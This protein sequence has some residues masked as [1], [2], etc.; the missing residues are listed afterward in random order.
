MTQFSLIYTSS[1]DG[2]N[3]FASVRRDSF[4]LE[5]LLFSVCIS[6]RLQQWVPNKWCGVLKHTVVAVRQIGIFVTTQH[7][8]I[9]IFTIHN[10]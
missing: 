8:S 2:N 5:N 1:Y 10:I 3:R 9:A 6:I 7:I 4:P